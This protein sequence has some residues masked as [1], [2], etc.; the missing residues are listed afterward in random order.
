MYRRGPTQDSDGNTDGVKEEP[1]VEPR[2]VD[3]SIV[4]GKPRTATTTG[5]LKTAMDVSKND[6]S[7]QNTNMHDRNMHVHTKK[8]AMLRDRTTYASILHGPTRDANVA[9]ELPEKR[10]NVKK[11][12]V[13][14]L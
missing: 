14:S 11:S 12:C 3:G 10:K 9:D 7:G 13:L 1:V 6:N 2:I 4:A 5:K 8:G